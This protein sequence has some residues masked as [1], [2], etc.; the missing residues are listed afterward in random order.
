MP[1]CC[2]SLVSRIYGTASTVA[3][4]NKAF[5]AWSEVFPSAA[6]VVS[7]VDRLVD[8]AEVIGI[9]IVVSRQGSA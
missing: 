2:S 6:C 8:R 1:T 7:L 5:K 4:T 9:R 3:T